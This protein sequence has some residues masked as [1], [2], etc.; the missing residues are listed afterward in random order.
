M[1]RFYFSIISL[2]VQHAAWKL[3]QQPRGVSRERLRFP[4]AGNDRGVYGRPISRQRGCLERAKERKT[5]GERGEV[6]KHRGGVKSTWRRRRAPLCYG[7]LYIYRAF[8]P[9]HPP[10]L[11]CFTVLCCYVA[12]Y[13]EKVQRRLDD[14]SHL[15]DLPASE[16]TGFLPSLSSRKREES[17]SFWM[18][19]RLRDNANFQ[20]GYFGVAKIIPFRKIRNINK[21]GGIF[22]AIQ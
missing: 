6:E 19:F 18:K 22:L 3:L 4:R 11:L 10:H 21:C 17:V 20:I 16:S 12:L 5:D 8:H 9:Q 14:V 15:P 2:H 1:T 13:I 7:W